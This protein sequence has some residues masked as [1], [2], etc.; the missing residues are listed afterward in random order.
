MIRTLAVSALLL[1]PAVASAAAQPSI[2]NP[3]DNEASSQSPAAMFAR[4]TPDAEAAGA[5]RFGGSRAF[6]TLECRGGDIAISGDRNRL[7]L[8][9][10]SRVT[11][12]GSRNDISVTLSSPG[13][14]TV[15]GGHNA[16]TYR[17]PSDGAPLVTDTGMDNRIRPVIG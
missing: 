9:D 6:R 8:V 3:G 4:Q 10:C 7:K 16:V 1:G 17:T 13:E 2:Y 15:S 5:L 12:S 11:L 14:I